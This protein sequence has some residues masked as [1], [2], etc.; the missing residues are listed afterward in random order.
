MADET[1]VTVQDRTKPP[2]K[3][4]VA[5]LLWIC[6]GALVLLFGLCSIFAAVVTLIQGW[7]EHNETQWPEVAA[8]VKNRD[9]VP[10]R[11]KS[12]SF[13][14]KCTITFDARGEA[15]TT[16]FFSRTTPA[17]QRVIWQSPPH[18]FENMHDWV[19][20]HPPGTPVTVQYDPTN[21]NKVVLFKTGMPGAGPQTPTNIKLLAFFSI[22]FLILLAIALATRP[23]TLA[24]NRHP[25]CA[26]PLSH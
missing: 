18:Q 26:A 14:I 7:Q 15:V 20:Q 13:R 16:L 10:Y 24:Q 9:I 12:Q 1:R 21:P 19:G 17:P 5:G 3:V 23:R 2:G 25:P 4:S 8:Q 11:Y 6:V 22:A